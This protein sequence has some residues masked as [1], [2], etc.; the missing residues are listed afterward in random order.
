MTQTSGNGAA[1]KRSNVLN[2]AVLQAAKPRGV[3]T[4]NQASSTQT[5]IQD[6]PFYKVL[7]DPNLS[8]EERQAEV[9]RLSTTTLDSKQDRANI[10]AF[11]D[12]REWMTTQQTTLAE[13][14]I[15]LTNV[16]AT[17]ELQAVLKDMNTDLISFED[18]MN[19]ML[20][21]IE[22][23]HYLRTNNLM[24][25]AFRDLQRE[26]EEALAR[27]EQA[28]RLE[29]EIAAHKA[30]IAQQDEIRL[31]ALTKR[32]FF[33]MGGMTSA[34]VVEK[35]KAE[36]AIAAAN[37]AI[38]AAKAT[39]TDL[40]AAKP[41]ATDGSDEVA[42]HRA[43]L[44]ELLD[45]SRSDNQDRMIALRDSASKFIDTARERT[46]SLR[47]QFDK[48]SHQIDTAKDSTENM[49]KVYAILNDGMKDAN[50]KNAEIR[51][52]LG[53]ASEGES[54]IETMTR[55]QNL[56]TL[57]THVGH[58]Q[59]AQGETVAT[60]GALNQQAIRIHTM[61]E[62]TG[63]QIQTARSINTDG[64]AA[65]ADRMATVMTAVAGAAL[66]EASEAAKDTLNR[67]RAST[68]DIAA[69]EVIRVA[70]GTSLM[71]QQL[72]TVFQEL[73]QAREVTQAATQITRN[74]MQDMQERMAELK[75][76]AE[77][78]R[79][80]LN[81]HIASASLTEAGLQPTRAAAQTA[82]PTG[83]PEV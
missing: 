57:D 61:S 39:I 34:A 64:V 38:D 76:S 18:K 42:V 81:A 53:P 75:A 37:T 16:D 55:E 11:D 74:A 4:A 33:G 24:G 25:D 54:T 41:P 52:T 45:M 30:T 63:Q 43:R 80:D 2:D 79:D 65:T 66:G 82:A 72:E 15:K 9:T 50:Q 40:R 68:T 17:A 31:H 62:A 6:N 59:R 70:M 26:R 10:K 20:Q 56:R 60:F 32:S 78:A 5:A 44:K 35:T 73:E 67:M 83:F 19:P 12:F 21:I 69:S 22:S 28:K 23:I 27:E 1:L 49:I 58:L 3:A 47:N 13:Q 8:L 71:N 77:A 51:G 36:E 46:G 29:E 7:F 48:Q 14:I